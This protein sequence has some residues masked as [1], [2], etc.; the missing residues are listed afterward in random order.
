VKALHPIER[1]QV[2]VQRNEREFSRKD[3]PAKGSAAPRGGIILTIV[4]RA[5]VFT[6]VSA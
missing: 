6:E 1:W 4:T 5:R 3:F 2:L